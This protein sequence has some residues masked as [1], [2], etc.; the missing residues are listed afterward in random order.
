MVIRCIHLLGV[1]PLNGS[2]LNEQMFK[3]E[4]GSV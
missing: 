2:A 4:K 1:F 3:L